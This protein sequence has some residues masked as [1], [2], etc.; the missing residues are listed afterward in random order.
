MW[1]LSI[2]W[3]ELILRCVIVYFFLLILLRISGKRQV[4]QLNPFDLVLL[5]VLSNAV[6]NA[7]TGGDNS[8]LGGVISALS[9]VAINYFVGFATF[10]NKRLEALVEGRPEVL[11]HNG[12]LYEDVM[13]RQKLTHHELNSALRTGGCACVDEVHLAVLEIDGQISV[14]PRAKPCPPAAATSPPTAP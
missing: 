13:D 9:L 4:G 3:Y 8:L 11:I 10:K 6:Q 1:N 5:L 7:M 12:T 14:Q 2:P